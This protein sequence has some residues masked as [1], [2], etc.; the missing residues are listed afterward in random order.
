CT[1][2]TSCTTLYLIRRRCSG[3][4]CREALRFLQSRFVSTGE[5]TDVRRQKTETAA[6]TE[7]AAPGPEVSGK[8]T[9]AAHPHPGR[10][11]SPAGAAQK[12][13]HWGHHRDVRFGAHRIPRNGSSAMHAV[14][15]RE[16]REALRSQAGQASRGR[17]ARQE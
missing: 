15:K 1:N 9:G 3:R 11:H 4:R 14:E 5:K 12:R 17:A 7:T 2:Q 6:C 8:H 16:D 13:G 10:I